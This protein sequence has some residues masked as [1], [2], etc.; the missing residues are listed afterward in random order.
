M[1]VSK[2]LRHE[3]FRRDN[4]TC[5]SCGAKAPDVK[6]EPDH[7]IPTAL[8]GSD[9]PSNLQTLCENCNGGKSATPPDAATVAKVAD[10]AARWARA[11]QVAAGEMLSAREARDEARA[12]FDAK[13][14][15]WSEGRPPLPR[16]SGWGSTVDNLLAAGLPLPVLL[17][18][19]DIAMNARQVIAADVFKYMCGVAWKQV[20]SL[21]QAASQTVS[22]SVATPK[23][24]NRDH[25]VSA[26]YSFTQTEIEVYLG[27]ARSIREWLG[28]AVDEDTLAG[29]IGVAETEEGGRRIDLIKL[30]LEEYTDDGMRFWRQAY[31]EWRAQDATTQP[32]D[33][34]VWEYAANLAVN[35]EVRGQQ[36]WGYFFDLSE[37]ARSQWLEYARKA[38]ADTLGARSLRIEASRIAFD[39]SEGRSLPPGMCRR[40]TS[41]AIGVCLERSAFSVT[42]TGC[43][44]CGDSCSGHEL[45]QAHLEALMD[46][47]R[48]ERRLFISDY[49]PL[50]GDT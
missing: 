20:R 37:D 46:D 41:T 32:E 30:Y 25:Y 26:L 29:A 42:F 13:W 43:P 40:R 35:D 9:D 21:Q 45:C 12:S 10:D 16:P 50:Q 49:T 17:D 2:R 7:V 39:A 31:E 27:M 11:M 14:T 22:A 3:I 8:G 19:V 44:T 47:E 48:P 36:A 24:P 1:A 18:C 34:E 23:V 28:L 6:L 5:Q 38:L 4:H 33:P 15:S